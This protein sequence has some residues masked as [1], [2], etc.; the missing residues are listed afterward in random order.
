MRRF[1][2]CFLMLALL[3]QTVSCHFPS[4][5]GTESSSVTSAQATPP[6]Q[7]PLPFWG[8]QTALD[9]LNAD[10]IVDTSKREYSYDEMAQDL[11]SLAAAYPS[12]FKVESIGTSIAGRNLYLGILGNPSAPRQIIVS[13]AI[14]GREYLTSLLTMKQIEFYLTYYETGN[15]N[16]ISYATLFDSCCFYIVPMSNPDGVMLS[17]EGLYSIADPALRTQVERIYAK[18]L[19]EG[20]TSQENIDQFLQYWKANAAGTDLNRN[21]DAL[22]E[23][24]RGAGRPCCVQ[25]KGP[26]PASEPETR[27]LVELTER[28]P[29]V[30]AV[31]CIHSQGEVLYWNCGQDESLKQTTLRFTQAIADRTGYKIIPE[32]NNDASYSDWCAL[33]KGLVAV[34]VETGKGICPL[35]LDKFMPMWEDH[36]DLLPLSAAYFLS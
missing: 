29:N 35:D 22:W 25:Y 10:G 24:Y 11:L 28:L 7:S 8:T 30:C 16:G 19:E 17:Q 27:A 21:F 1:F 4:T 5:G 36:F 23:E 33:E 34:T 12:R 2:I 15:Y 3:L 20:Y 14:H 9:F 18:D 26:T 13:A 32:Q 31:L 6:T